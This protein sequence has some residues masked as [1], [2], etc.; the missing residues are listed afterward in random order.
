MKL[1]TIAWSGVFAWM[2]LGAGVFVGTLISGTSWEAIV[3]VL[4]GMIA[5]VVAQ[6]AGRI[7]GGAWR[8]RRHRDE[9]YQPEPPRSGPELR[10]VFEA[11][12]DDRPG[13]TMVFV[14][15]E[16]ELGQSVNAGNWRKRN[17]GYWEL[18]IEGF[19]QSTPRK[20]DPGRG[21]H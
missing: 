5:A 21:L 4:A 1:W 2:L 6:L 8:A 18:A 11:I 12:A 16:D 3:Y 10:I 9:A 13:R 14:E 15:V 20:A 7:S 19:F 17:D